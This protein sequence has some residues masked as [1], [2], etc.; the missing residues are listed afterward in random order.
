MALNSD[1][2]SDI[3]RV[4]DCVPAAA[5]AKQTR[6]ELLVNSYSRTIRHYTGRQFK[7]AETALTKSFRYDGLGLLILSKTE[8]RTVSAIVLFS[9]LPAAD[10]VTLQPASGSSE[11]DYRLEPRQGTLEGTYLQIALKRL[12]GWDFKTDSATGNAPSRSTVFAQVAITGDWGA[13]VVPGDVE[14]ALM[15]A[16]DNAL[17]NPSAMASQSLGGLSFSEAIDAADATGQALPRDARALLHEYRRD[18]Y[19]G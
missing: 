14:H 11:A 10:Q 18:A 19:V 6:L 13:A 4:K 17:K 2:L 12:C 16:I 8:L 3:E 7:P 5:N 9:D 1:A 15:I